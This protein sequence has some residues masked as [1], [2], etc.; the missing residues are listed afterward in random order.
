MRR[1]P[2]LPAS[3]PARLAPPWTA[4]GVV[5]LT[6]LVW[7]GNNVV[8]KIGVG[9]APTTGLAA[10]RFA[11]AAVCFVVLLAAT[12]RAAFAVRREDWPLLAALGLTGIVASNLLF[13]WGLTLAPVGDAALIA[14]A[15]N[16]LW[17]AGLAAWWLGER[18]TRRQLVGMGVSLA[19]VIAVIGAAGLDPAGGGARL[20]GDLLLLASSA[21]WSVYTV[22][23][24]RALRRHSTLA[25][26]TWTTVLGTVPLIAIAA[27][28]GWDWLLTASPG[29]WATILYLAL[30]GSVVGLLT[31]SW[32]VR[33]LGAARAGQFTYLV[34]L[35]A[36][37]LAVLVLGE[38]PIPLQLAGAA[39]VLGGIWLTNRAPRAAP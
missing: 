17:T 18:Y 27:P 20:V 8:A 10:A 33:D 26:V 22:L 29:L 35:W 23:G 14:P 32:S 36:L 15:T 5:L 2:A 13:F 11:L 19:G 30:L 9:L 38:R 12:D 34:P 7:G 1:S 16:P 21:S 3:T 25:A 31:W 6:T 37:L 24:R 28:A 39:L 4:Y